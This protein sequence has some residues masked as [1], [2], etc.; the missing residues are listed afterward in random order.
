MC[1]IVEIA[2]VEMERRFRPIVIITLEQIY[3]DV[4][5]SLS[6]NSAMVRSKSRKRSLVIARQIYCYVSCKHDRGCTLNRIAEL[7]GRRHHTT[8]LSSNKAAKKHIKTVV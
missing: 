3:E 4:V 6:M 5:D 8:I 2:I 1:R 7:I